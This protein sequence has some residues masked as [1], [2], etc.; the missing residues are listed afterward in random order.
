LTSDFIFQ[1]VAELG[2]L[3]DAFSRQRTRKRAEGGG[4]QGCRELRINERYS[5]R[6]DGCDFC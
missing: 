3:G 1:F 5:R 6:P 2:P 4:E